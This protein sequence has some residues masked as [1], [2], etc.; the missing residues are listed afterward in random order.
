MSLASLLRGKRG[1]S[2]LRDL[3]DGFGEGHATA[4]LGA[5]RQLLGEKRHFAQW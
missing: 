3:Y 5:A 2:L 4:D 1:H